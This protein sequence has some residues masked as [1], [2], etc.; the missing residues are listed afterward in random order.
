MRI[1]IWGDE[2]S[3]QVARAGGARLI[4]EAL[5][6]ITDGLLRNPYGF[7]LVENDHM[8]FRYAKTE[9]IYGRLGALTVIFTI[10]REKNV[11]LQW[12]DEEIPF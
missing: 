2:F 9:P 7:S 1:I 8:S 11:V 5:S 3:R 10:D 4:D 12:F 6:P